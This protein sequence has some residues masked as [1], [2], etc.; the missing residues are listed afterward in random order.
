MGG[1]YTE[2][3]VIS[4]EVTLCNKQTANHVMWHYANWQLWGKEEDLLAWKGL[5]GYYSKEECIQQRLIL[6]GKLS[7][8]KNQESGHIKS[9]G[10]IYGAKAMVPGGWLYINR[11]DYAKLGYASGIGKAENRLTNEE[12]SALAKQTYANGKGL[13]AMSLEEKIAA[14]VKAGEISGN[15]HKINKTG[16]CGIPP[17]EHSKRMSETNKQK[18]A[19]PVCGY[20]NIARH[21]NKHMLEKHNLTKGAKIKVV[22]G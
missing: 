9:L 11:V 16:V 7:G 2:N 13:A 8:T 22:I 14:S 19:C 21:V 10:E 1:K 20:T 17:E 15:L 3:N 5:S 4:V 6:G 12:L 18:W